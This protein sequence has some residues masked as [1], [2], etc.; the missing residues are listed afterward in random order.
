MNMKTALLSVYDKTGIIEFATIL[1]NRGFHLLSTG[2]TAKHLRN[3]GLKV[4]EISEY[5]EFPEILDGRL[6][7][8]HPKIYGGLLAKRD[9]TAHLNL[10]DFYKM[11]CIDILVVNLY[12]FFEE[13]SKSSCTLMT[14]I[15]NI[16]IGGPAMIRAAAKNHGSKVNG[17]TVVTDP[18]DYDIVLNDMDVLGNNSHSLRFNFAKKA[19]LKTAS[20]DAE[21]SSYLSSFSESEPDKN[22][23]PNQDYW[24]EIINLQV[25]KKETLRYGENPHQKAAF[26]SNI[27]PS[28]G[29]ISNFH[30]FQGKKLSYNNI[31]DADA[32]WECIRGFEKPA[33]AIIKHA[34]PCGVAIGTDSFDAYKK[35][36]KT[37]PISSFGGTIAFNYK[38]DEKIFKIL[39]EQFIE[40]LIA[41]DYEKNVLLEL[42]KKENIRVL[43]I[44]LGKDQNTLNIKQIGG[45]IL[46]QTPDLENSYYN[47]SHV[48]TKRFPNQSEIE[49]LNFAW[50]VSKHIKSNAIV[51]SKN[52]MTL[53]IGAGQMSRIDSVRLACIKAREAKLSLK[54][55]V[56]ASDAFFPFQDGLKLAI[57]EGV[58]CII[59]P[60]GSIRDKEIIEFA[61]EN[62]ISMLIT[63]I[64]HFRH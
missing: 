21:I 63:G 48:V 32:A 15:E 42:K 3:S 17:V 33:C 38:L 20:Y 30:Q 8:L 50:H 31:A 1:N 24:P 27:K 35:A 13:I 39:S 59:H 58:S 11:N 10:I 64:R 56:L 60:G 5:T 9:E 6:K 2:G 29:L 23:I 43:K 57:S 40:T 18:N 4:Q 46:V 22:S 44:P 26:Y 36:F 51:F 61:D 37:D 25:K 54:G 41:P 14:A 28:I 49:D 16:D 34:N 53:G 47:I 45:G 7:T 52:G 12:P 62:N 19:Y 55:S